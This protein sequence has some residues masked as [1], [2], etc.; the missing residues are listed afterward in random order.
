MSTGTIPLIIA[1]TAMFVFFIIVATLG[2]HYSLNHI[3]NKTVGN[4]QHGTA[5]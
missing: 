4:G 1:T 5:R 2:N 3:K